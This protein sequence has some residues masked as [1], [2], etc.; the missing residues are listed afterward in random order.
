MQLP[1]TITLGQD[2]HNLLT[3]VDSGA[4]GNFM[5]ASLASRLR[6]PLVNLKSPLS[7][8]ALDGR[9]LGKGTVTHLTSP[10]HMSIN[11]SHDENIQFNLVSSPEF[12]VVLG[13][14]W[15]THHSPHIN[16]STG[17]IVEWGPG[18]ASSCLLTR[19]KSS[20]SKPPSSLELSQV[21]SE[22]HDLSEVFNKAR[23]TSLPP[24]R[25]YDCSIDLLR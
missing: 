8:T 10:V 24:H 9:P 23:A 16:W 13:F 20:A 2:H 1:I 5:D 17:K 21:P 15:L 7:V 12:T 6:L 25:P 18:C 22:Y 4:A 14:P 3:L 11:D 19:S